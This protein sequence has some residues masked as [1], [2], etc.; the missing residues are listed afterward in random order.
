M[1][2]ELRKEI[3]RVEQENNVVIVKVVVS[4]CGVVYAYD[5][6]VFLNKE[7]GEWG[8]LDLNDCWEL[9]FEPTEDCHWI[10]PLYT[11]EEG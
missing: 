4:E 2:E 7:I 11:K 1:N 3:E 6:E 9:D 5:H 10:E 8:D